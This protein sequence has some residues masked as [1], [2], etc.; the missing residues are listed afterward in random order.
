MRFQLPMTQQE[1]FSDF[2]AFLEQQAVH[3][4]LRLSSLEDIF[5]KIGMDP[6]SVLNNEPLPDL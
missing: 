2:F 3:F 6:T 1:Y 4:S 5:I